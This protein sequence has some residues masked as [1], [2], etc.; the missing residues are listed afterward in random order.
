MPIL[1]HCGRNAGGKRFAPIVLS[2]A[3]AALALT[4]A[5]A[6]C[7]MPPPPAPVAAAPTPPPAPVPFD[8]AVQNAATA[9]LAATPKGD[10]E[11]VVVIDPLVSGVTGEQS[12]ATRTIGTRITSIAQD[13][14]PQFKVSPFTANAVG[15]S[16]LVM[17]GT[18]TPVNA[19][20]QPT[21]EREAFRFCLVMAD[22]ASGKIVAKSVARAQPHGVDSSPIAFFR[23]SPAWTDD[24]STKAYIDTCQASK[25]G[26]AIN[27]LYVSGILASAIVSDAIDAYDDGRYRDALEL[28]RNA[29]TTP[30]GKQLRVYNGVYL[31]TSKVGAKP[32]SAQAFG[33]LV[34]YGLDKNKLAVKLLFKPG[35]TAFENTGPLASDYPMWLREIAE[36]GAARNACLDVVGHTSKSGSVELNQQLSLARARIVQ[37]R[38]ERQAPA[39]HGRIMSEGAGDAA[40]LVGTGADNASDALD[41]RVEFKT[42]ANCG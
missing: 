33:D 36:R 40:P 31:A 41:R 28:Y 8:Q 27:P 20:N 42:Q 22:L 3:L 39:L 10:T 5:L 35:S 1:H 12:V 11:R 4:G 29:L 15:K 23:D 34:D 30:S 24:A 21:G 14:F 2:T 17:V 26:D 16:P 9:V 6:G 37:A 7:Q 32:E 13:R 18:F 25:V 19:S 38:I